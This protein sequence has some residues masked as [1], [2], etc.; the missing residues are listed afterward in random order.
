MRHAVC[1]VQRVKRRTT[2][3]IPDHIMAS[4]R[5]QVHAQVK[6]LPA[7]APVS[8][9]L[10]YNVSVNNV[11]VG[12]RARVAYEVKG[13]VYHKH[14]NSRSGGRREQVYICVTSTVEEA[15]RISD[16]AILLERRRQ[17]LVCGNLF[18]IRAFTSPCHYATGT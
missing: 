1:R 18:S 17:V 16:A 12:R 5:T 6:G 13:T 3:S 8:Q 9:C 11:N 15:A 14:A 10:P 4:V 7:K 2:G